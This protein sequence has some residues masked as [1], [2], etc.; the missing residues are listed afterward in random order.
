MKKSTGFVWAAGIALVLSSKCGGN[1]AGSLR[2]PEEQFSETTYTQQVVEAMQSYTQA[3][4]TIADHIGSLF[5][6]QVQTPDKH[7]PGS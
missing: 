5:I 2:T 4:E 6:D 1:E 7:R 3:S